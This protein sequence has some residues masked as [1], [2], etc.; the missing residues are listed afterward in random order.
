MVTLSA[1][2]QESLKKILIGPTLRKSHILFILSW[3]REVD[4][5]NLLSG[6]VFLFLIFKDNG[7]L[8]TRE[9]SDS[10]CQLHVIKPE[11]VR[12]NVHWIYYSLKNIYGFVCPMFAYFTTCD[13][14]GAHNCC[15]VLTTKVLRQFAEKFDFRASCK[16]FPPSPQTTLNFLFL[17]RPQLLQKIEWGAWVIREL[18]LDGNEIEEKV[19]YGKA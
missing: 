10:S 11:M 7:K 5:D 3:S 9:L 13:H 6:L 2:E 14:H 19:K 8:P 1:K 16:N 17:H 15:P 4:E 18:T 12:R